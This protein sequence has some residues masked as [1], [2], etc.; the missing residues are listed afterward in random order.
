MKPSGIGGQAVLEGVMMKNKDHYAIAVRKPNQ[1]IEVKK[2]TY[3][4]M[5]DRYHM[6]RLPILRGMAAFVDSMKI[7]MSTLNYSAS[8]YEE[9]ENAVP[10]KF[11]AQLKRWFGDRT[12]DVLSGVSIVI[13]VILAVAI[14]VLFPTYISQCFSRVIESRVLLAIL[15]GIIRILLFVGYIAIISQIKDIK[16][17]FMYHGAEHKTIQ[18]IEHGL[19]LTVENV[20]KQSKEHRR[21]GTSFLLLIMMISIVF[22]MII[23]MDQFWLKSIVRILLIP[24]IAGVSYE[25]IRLAGSSDRLWIRVLSRPGLWLQ[26]L[27]TKE[28]DDDM[29]EVAIASVDAVFDWRAFLQDFDGNLKEMNNTSIK[30]EKQSDNINEGQLD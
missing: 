18:C 10:S 6:F 12:E 11:E 29:I 21:C 4:S 27:T 2:E 8:F 9:E 20:R 25:F 28:P 24:I 26:R 19:E 13:S 7:G 22:F 14:F 23:R 17:V 16:R 30:N 1:E 3:I 15:E 5:S